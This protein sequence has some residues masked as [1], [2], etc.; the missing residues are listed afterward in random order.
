MIDKTFKSS[1]RLYACFVD[2]K[3]AYDTVNRI[4]LFLKLSSLNI[5]RNFFNIL[6]DMYREVSFSVKFT[7]DE[8]APLTSKVGVN[9]GCIL[10]P[11]LFSLYINDL[12]WI[13]D[14]LCEPTK[15]SNK[16]VSDD[17]I[18]LSE[19]PSGL[20]RC[21]D[22]LNDYCIKWSLTVNNA[23][24]KIIVFNK[25]GKVLKDTFYYDNNVLVNSNEYEYLDIQALM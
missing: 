9:Q 8:T 13:F 17:V 10:T 24:T 6:K 21:L 7:E 5:S 20:Q 11:T 12:A 25:S 1:K 23:N 15:L 19:S 22:K 2:L 14:S 4:A 16:N 18:L 3:K